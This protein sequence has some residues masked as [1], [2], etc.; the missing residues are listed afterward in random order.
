MSIKVVYNC[1]YGGFSISRDCAVR[2]A[3]LGNKEAAEMLAEDDECWY[4]YLYETPRHDPA[5]VQA[6]E[7]L[8]DS[9]SGGNASL[10]VHELSGNR[11]IVRE[12]DGVESVVEPDDI[13]WTVV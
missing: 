5:L 3:A 12:Y 11:Y 1:C 13:R 6:V 10:D 9:A 7:E 4:G 8:G 2:M